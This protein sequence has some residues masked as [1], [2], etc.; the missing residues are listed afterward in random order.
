MDISFTV[1]ALAAIVEPQQIRGDDSLTVTKIS[2][3][4]DAGP[5]DLTFLGNPKYRAQVAESRASVILLP[6]DYEEPPAEGQCFLIVANP[7]VALARICARIEQSLWPRPEPGIH[8]SA[9]VAASAQIADSATI[10]PLCVVEEDAVI[11]ER[12]HLQAQVFVGRAAVVGVDCWMAAGSHLAT[13]CELGDRVRL[14]GGVI[15]GADGFGYEVVDGRHAKVPQ[16]GIVKVGDDVEIGAN[17]TIDRAR[18]SQT[19]IGEGSKIDNQVQVAH[20]VV[21]GRHCVLCAQVG[22]AGSTT[23]EDYV[24]MG[25][26]SGAAGHIRVAQGTQVAGRGGLTANITEPGVVYSGMPAM[27][28]RLERR[29]VVLQRRLPDLFK[30]VKSLLNDLEELKKA[31]AN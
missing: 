15:I 9:V 30:D 29:L 10:G 1:S 18:F 13:A 19:L 12:S 2:A 25:G 5:G 23:L 31:S 16:V 17:S 22:I 6:A 11:G 26:Q 8:P 27:P 28:Y 20:N 3:L 21:V 24:V 7:S 14:H 4:D